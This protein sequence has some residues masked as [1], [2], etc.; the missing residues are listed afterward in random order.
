MSKN[1]QRNIKVLGCDTNIIT[2][3][4][5]IRKVRYV[6]NSSNQLVLRVDEH[7][8]CDSISEQQL[9]HIKQ[10]KYD[11]IVISDYSSVHF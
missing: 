6:D 1:V 3:D 4:N 2:N 9:Q 5:D 7:D 11:A 8:Y 10:E